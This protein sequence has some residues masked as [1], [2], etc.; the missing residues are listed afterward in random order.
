MSPNHIK[1]S[2]IL[3][4]A[5]LSL[6]QVPGAELSSGTAAATNSDSG[7]ALNYQEILKCGPNSLYM[8]LILCG[9]KSLT[10][11]QLNGIAISTNGSSLLELRDVAKQ[12]GVD[13]EIRHF[14]PAEVEAMPLPAIGQFNTSPASVT[15][16]HFDV[17]YGFD[18]VYLH[19]LNGTTGQPFM[20][21]RT[22]LPSFWTG[23]A[24]VEKRSVFQRTLQSG[25]MQLIASVVAA[26]EFAALVVRWPAFKRKCNAGQVA[27]LNEKIA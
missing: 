14:S 1:Y 16:L 8:F 6:R 15:R 18:P 26:L 3:L 9:K 19:L 12:F 17:I 20:I 23:Y 5:L 27:P 24:M 21:R 25:R 22:K 11:E 13:T 7:Y 10:L 2:V 4:V